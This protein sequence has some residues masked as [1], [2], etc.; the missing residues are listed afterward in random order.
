MCGLNMVLRVGWVLKIVFIVVWI[1]F[2]FICEFV[3]RMLVCV[4]GLM[5]LSLGSLMKY[6]YDMI[7]DFGIFFSEFLVI[8]WI[9]VE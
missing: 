5:F 9:W 7:I 2:W 1:C 6:E 4:L 8:F 3:I